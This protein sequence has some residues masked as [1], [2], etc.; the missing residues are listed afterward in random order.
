MMMYGN[1]MFF[2]FIIVSLAGAVLSAFLGKRERVARLV[3]FGA[4]AI[5]SLLGLAVSLEVLL[6]GSVVTLAIP[7]SVPALGHF[8]LVVDSLS[9][10]FL[11]AISILA[12]CVSVYSIGYTK[13]YE[14]R[15]STGAMGFVFNVFL[16]SLV[17]VVTAS[18]A[19]LFLI[20]W[21]TMSLSSYLLVVY[22]NRKQRSVSSGLLYFVM[23]HLGTALITAAFVLM[24]LNMPGERSFDFSA[25]GS[26]SS[27]GALPDAIRNAAF[28]LLLVGFGTKAG[29]VPLHVWLP[30]AH[31]AA[32]SNVSA[33]MSGIMVKTAVYMLIRCVFGFLG[34]H[35]A[36][37][38]L[39]VLLIACISAL[40]GVLYALAETDIKRA[41]AFSTVENM[42]LIFIA[43]GAAMVFQSYYLADPA[44]NAFLAD[45]A[46]LALIASL[47][48]VLSHSLFK[49]LLF[50]G[51]GAVMYATHTKDMEELGG[52]AKRMK[53]T[54]GL[55]FIGALSISAIPP[56]NGFVSE[57]LMLQSLL[58]TQNIHDAMLNLLIPIA[59]GVLALTGA[60]AAACFVRLFGM[61]FLARPRSR[62]AAEAREVP[63]SMLVGMGIAAALC[64]LTGVLSVLIIPAIDTVTSSVLGVS[65]ADKL[66]NGVILSPPAGEFSSMSPLVIGALLLFAVPAAFVISRR[67]GGPRPV[68]TGDTWDCGTPLGPRNEYTATGFSQPVERVFRSV[69]RP[70][71]EVRTEPSSSPLIKRKISYAHSD[72][73]VFE[74]YLY[75]PVSRVMVWLATKVS[76]IQKGSI[77]AYLAYIFVVLLV[78]LVVFR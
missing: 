27:A 74:R 52:L 64:I 70:H 3:S 5:S 60:L 1:S 39:L 57:W 18:N 71:A 42:G 68:R 15:Y 58:L 25:F 10:Y 72:E 9:A 62:H 22:E 53:W 21:E 45:L 44:G 33:M 29:L 14:G 20:V 32:P 56:F 16:L 7:T 63:K 13:E 47:F 24:W 48:H 36:W 59:V 65:I 61:T 8:S 35:D 4:A 75:S 31:P 40:L 28:L 17:L 2:A 67:L 46:A 37:W 30:Q 51:A 77:Q 55:F 50:M 49:G 54:G 34:V 19:V 41:L 69:Y 11:L 23:T 26:L 38:G 66:V 73:P 6:G 43:V 12:F 76:V 78:L